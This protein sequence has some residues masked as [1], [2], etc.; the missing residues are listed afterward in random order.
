MEHLA[1]GDPGSLAAA[2]GVWL[3]RAVSGSGRYVALAVGESTLPA[4]RLLAPLPAGKTVLCLDELVP[5][6]ARVGVTFA[7]RL[8]HVLP[9]TWAAALKPFAGPLADPDR[10]E[11]A[12]AEDGLAAAVCGVGPD[13]HVA[14]NQPPDDGTSRT[15]RVDLTAENL[16]RLGDVAPATGALTLGLATIAEAA[17]LAVVAV[18][19]GKQEPIRRLLEGPPGDDCPVSRLAG[20]PGLTVFSGL[21][22]RADSAITPTGRGE[23]R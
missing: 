3:D 2:V 21:R 4:F 7:S 15:R 12:I 17:R 9:P 13:G 20:H 5:A 22:S 6:P 19:P 10:I 23:S 14:F 18:G 11:A 1:F 16:A 8:R